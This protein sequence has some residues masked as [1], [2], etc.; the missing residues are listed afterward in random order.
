[1]KR[2]FWIGL[3]AGGV[4][5]YVLLMI[6]T[7][8]L[9]IGCISSVALAA[10]GY[11]SVVQVIAYNEQ[12]KAL[13]EAEQERIAIE[14]KEKDEYTKCTNEID[15]IV[16]DYPYLAAYRNRVTDQFKDFNSKERG[17]RKIIDYNN[18]N[19]EVFI[20][21]KSDAVRQYLMRNLKRFVKSMIAYS[22]TNKIDEPVEQIKPLDDILEANQ[23]LIDWY[24]KLIIEVARMHD[25]FNEEDADLQS[26]VE[27]LKELRIAN[28]GDDDLDD[29][30]FN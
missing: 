11:F 24:D 26:L 6:F 8:G 21:S 3:L 5:A 17:L 27:N 30:P 23:K 16:R 2:N 22:L 28:E 13:K 10:I 25:N 1:M 20:T 7:S 9:L 14:S 15:E 19:S 4:I 29:N 18:N 12:Q